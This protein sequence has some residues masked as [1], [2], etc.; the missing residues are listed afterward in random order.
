MQNYSYH[1]RETNVAIPFRVLVRKNG[2]VTEFSGETPAGKTGTDSNVEIV[3]FEY[4]VYAD[5]DIYIYTYIYKRLKMSINICSFI[6]NL[7]L[8]V[9]LYDFRVGPH[10]AVA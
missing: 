6:F 1:E 9:T 7:L 10:C 3:E 2:E 4:K 5:Y 8:H